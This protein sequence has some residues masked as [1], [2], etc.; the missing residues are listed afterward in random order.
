MT[1]LPSRP[2]P[3]DELKPV[4]LPPVDPVKQ[5]ARAYRQQLAEDY[6]SELSELRSY[7]QQ[8]WRRHREVHPFDDRHTEFVADIV[9]SLAPEPPPQLSDHKAFRLSLPYESRMSSLG[10]HEV[11]DEFCKVAV[12]RAGGKMRVAALRE[13]LAQYATMTDNE[14]HEFL[15]QAGLTVHGSNVL[16]ITGSTEKERRADYP[17]LPIHAEREYRPM[18]ATEDERYSESDF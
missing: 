7:A 2:F 3:A 12:Y 16:F 9:Q 17:T 8:E 4:V 11:L 1:D 13:A 15:D 6:R 14:F 5:A 18:L 10:E